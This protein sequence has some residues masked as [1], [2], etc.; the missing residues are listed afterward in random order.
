MDSANIVDRAC[1]EPDAAPQVGR[2]DRICRCLRQRPL[3]LFASVYVLL[4]TCN[5][6]H[7]AEPPYWD[8]VM[9]RF[10]VAVWLKQ[11]GFDLPRLW[12]EE[13]GFYEGGVATNRE[14]IAGY[15]YA[16]LLYVLPPKLLFRFLHL[17]NIG[18][19]SLALTL[20]FLLLHDRIGSLPALLWCLAAL[21]DPLFSG[22][23]ATIN[24]ELPMA[25][26]AALGIFLF[27]RH[28]FLA[29]GGA[30]ALAVLIKSTA[31]VAVIALVLTWCL[32]ACFVRTDAPEHRRRS[33]VVVATAGG[34]TCLWLLVL[35]RQFIPAFGLDRNWGAF[36]TF[37]RVTLP[38]FTVGYI[39]LIVA[40]GW[41]LAT[42]RTLLAYGETPLVCALTAL[43]LGAA[44]ALHHTP[45]PRYSLLGVFPMAAALAFFVPRRASNGLAIVALLW[46][47]ANQYGQFFP[48]LPG[49]AARSGEVLERSREFLVDLAGNR[50]VCRE[51]AAKH[52]DRPIVCKFPFIHM[53]TLPEMG[54]VNKALPKVY[55]VGIVPTTSSATRIRSL[56]EAPEDA[57]FL[58][59]PT[60]F[61]H[62]IR[63]SLLPREHDEVVLAEHSLGLPVIVYERRPVA[64]K[65]VPLCRKSPAERSETG[66]ASRRHQTRPHT[67]Y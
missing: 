40:L 63:P 41:T 64:S 1:A 14:S 39:L 61:E 55:G 53:L 28:K 62:T 18:C 52:A 60:R 6:P 8:A 2:L 23:T 36:G 37:C 7:L 50:A 9:G 32:R 12:T 65:A 56:A 10:S 48:E 5:A 38:S 24:I 44:I 34:I 49:C 4:L 20:F 35:G 42:K 15:A 59:S 25:T 57:L 3:L 47:S 58:F 31:L 29:S 21:F 19:A 51:L 30:L 46:A 45:L 17:L 11:T 13:P 66:P 27:D 33:F 43:G 22:Q 26:A 54:Y 16:A 67:A